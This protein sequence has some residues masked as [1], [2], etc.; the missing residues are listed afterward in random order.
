MGFFQRTGDVDHRQQ[1]EYKGLNKGNHDPHQ[2][3]RHGQQEGH[4]GKEDHQHDLMAIHVAEQ[5][6]SQ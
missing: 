2:H 3:H 1:H 6:Q 5:T 4:Q